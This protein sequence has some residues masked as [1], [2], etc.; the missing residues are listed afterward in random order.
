MDNIF[1]EKSDN[2]PK[3]IM[4]KNN[5]LIEFEGRSYPENT[6]AFYRPIT[7]WLKWY[8]KFHTQPTTATT[9]NFKLVYFNSATTQIIF[10]ILDI[11]EEANNKN[12]KI[13]WFYKEEN[14]NGF[15][16][17]EDYAEEFPRLNIEA[18]VV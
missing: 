5:A 7:E 17:Y 3:V 8:F 15:E 4:D 9:I 16:D 11:V 14:K 2:S 18:I 6:F 12:I 10:E 1:L 13:N